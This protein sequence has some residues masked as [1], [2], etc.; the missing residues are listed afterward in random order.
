MSK[1]GKTT[2]WN[3]FG[4]LII[5]ILLFC[6]WCGV[7]AALK[8]KGTLVFCALDEKVVYWVL[9]FVPLAYCIWY[10]Y[11]WPRKNEN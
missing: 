11:N 1:E 9:M 3:K 4:G 2:F 10:I 8:E 5:R 6:I 7:L